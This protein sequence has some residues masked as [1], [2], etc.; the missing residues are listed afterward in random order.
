MLIATIE[1]S[2]NM[3]EIDALIVDESSMID[4]NLFRDLV[5]LVPDGAQLILI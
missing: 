4:I 3:T 5:K 1:A 2:A